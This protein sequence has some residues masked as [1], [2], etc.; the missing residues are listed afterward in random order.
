M[1]TALIIAVII[2]PIAAYAL[3]RFT[4]HKDD[5]KMFVHYRAEI[6][7]LQTSEDDL[8]GSLY[9]RIGYQPQPKV[10][11]SSIPDRAQPNNSV[12]DKNHKAEGFPDLFRKREEAFAKDKKQYDQVNK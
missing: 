2:L 1:E 12:D 11:T 6:S 4:Q 8:R 7:R 10:E 9:H 3:G 5:E